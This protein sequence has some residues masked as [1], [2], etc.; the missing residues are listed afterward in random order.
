MRWNGTDITNVPTFIYQ[1]ELIRSR[2]DIITDPDGPGSLICVSSAQT[3]LDWFMV[4]GTINEFDNFQETYE[5]GPP[6]VSQLTQS[7]PIVDPP[8]R[9]ADTN[10]LW[11]CEASNGSPTLYVGIFGRF[12]GEDM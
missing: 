9:D 4:F 12:E 11:R 10:G 3:L 6:S 1:D 2:D 8:R 5:Q 7:I